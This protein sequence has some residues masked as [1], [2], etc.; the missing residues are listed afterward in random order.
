MRIAVYED[1]LFFLASLDS[2]LR[3]MGHDVIVLTSLERALA[4]EGEGVDLLITDLHAPEA[5]RLIELMLPTCPVVAFCGH[6]EVELRKRA[7]AAGVT[8]LLP[9]SELMQALPAVV[10]RLQMGSGGS[11]EDER[12]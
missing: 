10:A 4:P 5:F 1:N 3:Q 11:A 6:A 8:V 9:N 7:K 2:K 12:L